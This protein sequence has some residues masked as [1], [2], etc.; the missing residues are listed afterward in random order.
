MRKI[1]FKKLNGDSVLPKKKK[2][3]SIIKDKE[4]L[5]TWFRLR[6]IKTFTYNT[7]P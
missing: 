7:C 6:K 2:N 3:A 5:W 4:S 1:L